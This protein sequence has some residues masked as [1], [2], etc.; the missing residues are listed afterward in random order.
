M[1]TPSQPPVAAPGTGYTRCELAG[2]ASKGQH[3]SVGRFQVYD[4]E[5]RTMT[6]PAEMCADCVKFAKECGMTV[7]SEAQ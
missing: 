4:G 1:T 5:I 6:R 3:A 2:C 7:K